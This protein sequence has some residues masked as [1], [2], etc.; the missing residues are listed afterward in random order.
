MSFIFILISFILILKRQTNRIFNIRLMMKL[1][2][3]LFYPRKMVH[4]GKN[5]RKIQYLDLNHRRGLI[6]VT[7]MCLLIRMELVET[8]FRD[9]KIAFWKKT[10]GCGKAWMKMV[11][12][13]KENM[14]HKK[15]NAPI[16][17]VFI[18][19]EVKWKHLS[20]IINLKQG[21]SR[22]CWCTFNS[23]INGMTSREQ[24]E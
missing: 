21:K 12:L 3:L 9:L 14:P 19:I 18:N 23:Q 1:R 17:Y 4:R 15:Q 10:I 11:A 6:M 24:P 16:N 22:F 8:V 7:I 20:Q 13:E 5:Q 2:E